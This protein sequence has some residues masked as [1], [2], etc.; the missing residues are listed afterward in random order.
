MPRLGREGLWARTRR[1]LGQVKEFQL[2]SKSAEKPPKWFRVRS[3]SLIR[4]EWFEEDQRGRGRVM[5]P[6]GWVVQWG[7]TAHCQGQSEDM[8]DGGRRMTP[9]VLPYLRCR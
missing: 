3:L 1:P 7:G 4:G 8:G 6:R 2:D 5:V 9:R